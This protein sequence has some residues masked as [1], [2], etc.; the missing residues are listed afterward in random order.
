MRI[1]IKSLKI[2]DLVLNTNAP[3]SIS[4]EVA[5]E[6]KNFLNG[7]QSSVE[8][9]I[10]VDG[11]EHL[12]VANY[13]TFLQGL[14]IPVNNQLLSEYILFPETAQLNIDSIAQEKS[15]G[16]NVA[17]PSTNVNSKFQQL[18][19]G[20]QE[21]EIA[22]FNKLAEILIKIKN[23]DKDVSGYQSQKTNKESLNSKISELEKSK[24]NLEQKLASVQ[25][26]LDGKT[27]VESEVLKVQNEN[28]HHK[29]D[30]INKIKEER[31]DQLN[32]KLSGGFKQASRMAETYQIEPDPIKLK[33][34]WILALV[35]IQV[36]ASIVYFLIS[37][38]IG[39]L[40]LG[41]AVSMTFLVIFVVIQ[42]SNKKEIKKIEQTPVTPIPQ[43]ADVQ[44]STTQ[45]EDMKMVKGAYL[46]ALLAEQENINQNINKSLGGETLEN[47]QSSLKNTISQIEESKKSLEELE[48]QNID[49]D[50]YYKKR[51]ELDIL[52]I[53]K[54]NIEFSS[55]LSVKPDDE[56]ISMLMQGNN[57]TQN[58]KVYLPLV[59]F[60]KQL[61]FDEI[62]E[63]Y[64]NIR[65]VVVLYENL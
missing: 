6:I 40:L 45:A 12:S 52:K 3:V 29:T 36:L 39:L 5:S 21:N 16:L 51:R 1:D 61:R 30:E 35:V 60:C 63:K 11:Q 13:L 53:E 10:L 17:T 8:S 50:T 46:N 47:I 33:H 32:Q 14:Q 20:M 37:S 25:S 27:K 24:G 49:V 43:G 38:N 23:L 7:G 58:T 42:V 26:L 22:N 34:K 59:I 19:N 65:Q 31:I 55:N 48:K 9:N 15:I 44:L 28:A 54:E 62:I 2:K 4:S 56:Y 64:N 41:L 18:T 57:Q